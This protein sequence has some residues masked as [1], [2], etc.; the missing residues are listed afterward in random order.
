MCFTS[1]FNLHELSFVQTECSA[2]RLFGKLRERGSIVFQRDLATDLG[3]DERCARAA[4][5]KFND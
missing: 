1:V 3:W 4:S 5:I 2:P